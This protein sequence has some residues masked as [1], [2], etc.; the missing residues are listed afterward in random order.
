MPREDDPPESADGSRFARVRRMLFGHPKVPAYARSTRQ[1]FAAFVGGAWD[2]GA[3]AYLAL[4]FLVAA[5]RRVGGVAPIV[6][7]PLQ[8]AFPFVVLPAVIVGAVALLSRRG[9]EFVLA[10]ALLGIGWFAVQ[11]ARVRRP[12]A[13]GTESVSWTILQ[14]NVLFSNRTPDRVAATIK[15]RDTD[16][17]AIEELTPTISTALD[18]AGVFE[19]YPYRQLV[20]SSTAR[21][22]GL[23]SKYPFS[24]VAPTAPGAPPEVVI[25]RPGSVPLR[26]IVMHPSPPIK[27]EDADVWTSNLAGLARR[28]HTDTGPT[29]AIGDFN[30]TRW[31]PAFGAVLGAGARDSHE[32]LGRG[33]SF[34]WPTRGPVPPF[35]RLDHA[36]SW[37]GVVPT[38]LK[39]VDLPGSDHR[40]FVVTLAVPASID[41]LRTPI[42]VPGGGDTP[43]GG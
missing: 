15:A 33:L 21:G 31:Q 43:N 5:S 20:V 22:S 12:L 10:A 34:S 17:V 28:V 41:G 32:A 4:A 25:D 27:S 2:I 13:V 3:F 39:E 26:V 35:V 37:N 18:L 6:L 16:V 14:A 29:V 42:P 1:R 11:P 40:G 30:G 9:L 38:S 23:L 19:V 24:D 8:A 36:L 7:Q